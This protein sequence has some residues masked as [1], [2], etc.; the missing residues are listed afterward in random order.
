MF[1]VV[2]IKLPFAPNPYLLPHCHNIIIKWVAFPEVSKS[3]YQM[4]SFQSSFSYL[5][6]LLGIPAGTWPLSAE[7]PFSR[8]LSARLF[9]HV[10]TALIPSTP[11][12]SKPLFPASWL[13][14]LTAFSRSLFGY[15]GSM[16]S[17]PSPS[18]TCFHSPLNHLSLNVFSNTYSF[19]HLSISMEHLLHSRLSSMCYLVLVNI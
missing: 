19:V 13:Q 8:I 9:L 15:L 17:W 7:I 14:L 18:F 2:F 3:L 12:S 6:L 11:M 5:P 1:A 16:N 4:D 10:P